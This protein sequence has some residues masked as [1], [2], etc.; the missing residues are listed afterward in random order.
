MNLFSTGML[1]LFLQPPV[2]FPSHAQNV[3]FG[4]MAMILK[5]KLDK[6]YGAAVAFNGFVQAFVLDVESAGIV[7]CLAMNHLH[8]HFHFPNGH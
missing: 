6:M 4:C 2:L 1:H 5:R 3:F 7:I 8:W